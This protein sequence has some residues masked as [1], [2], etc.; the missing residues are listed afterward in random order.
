[1]LTPHMIVREFPRHPL[2][3]NVAPN[4][5]KLAQGDINLSSKPY[6]GHSRRTTSLEDSESFHM[7]LT[8]LFGFSPSFSATEQ[9]LRE[10]RAPACMCSKSW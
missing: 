2:Q 6:P 7:L 3:C 5:S 1:M 8:F 9:T 4:S 10:D